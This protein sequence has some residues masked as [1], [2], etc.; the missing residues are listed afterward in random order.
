M[1]GHLFNLSL[2]HNTTLYNLLLRPWPSLT[3]RTVLGLRYTG[4]LK[5]TYLILVADGECRVTAI[6]TRV[7]S[8]SVEIDKAPG[9]YQAR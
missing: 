9:T 4:Y 6:Y 5:F 2:G 1:S 7:A 8:Y 3:L